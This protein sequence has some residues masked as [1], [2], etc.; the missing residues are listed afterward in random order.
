M[1]GE[2]QG[3][4]CMPGDCDGELRLVRPMTYSYMSWGG[5]CMSGER[6]VGAVYVRG[7]AAGGC[8]SQGSG[9]GG[10]RACQGSGPGISVEGHPRG[11]GRDAVVS[12]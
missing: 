9:R 12:P 5:P 11:G 3:A 8:V 6:P 10:G 2:R 1:P 4:L 7:A